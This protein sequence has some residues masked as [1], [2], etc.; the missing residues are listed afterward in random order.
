MNFSKKGPYKPL[1]SWFIYIF[2]GT[3]WA[4]VEISHDKADIS[5]APPRWASGNALLSATAAHHLPP[6]RLRLFSIGIE[7]D[8]N[9]D[10][11][12]LSVLGGFVYVVEL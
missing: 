4:A 5:P 2:G 12:G 6:I 10:N 3:R 11:V 1:L 9:P 8:K 7:E